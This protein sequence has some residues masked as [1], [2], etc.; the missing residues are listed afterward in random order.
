MAVERKK[1]FIIDLG[2]LVKTR[3][4]DF[5]KS[6]QRIH[7][8]E[9][10]DFQRNIIDNDLSYQDQLDYRKDLLKREKEKKY[11]DNDFIEEIKTSISNL[12]VLV[13]QRKWRDEY[14][15]FLSDRIAGRKS[16]QDYL[17]FLE[18]S[19]HEG[20]NREIRDK[21]EEEI[22]TTQTE[23]KKN[24]RDIVNSQITF[25][26]KD[27]TID[28]IDK[29]IGLIQKQLLK[30]D[31]QKDDVLRNSYQLQLLTLNKERTEVMI[32]DKISEMSISLIKEEKK[33]NALFKLDSY[34]NYRDS[35][36]T[37]RPVN[38]GGVRYDTEREYWDVLLNNYIVNEFEKDYVTQ[39]RKNMNVL[40]NK[41]GIFPDS[42][43][44]D[45]MA[46][47]RIIKNHPELVNFP[48][49]TL[50]A[51]Q[52]VVG[53]MLDL[54]AQDLTRKYHLDEPGIAIELD[55]F[56]AEKEL[57]DLQNTIG[58]EY[59]SLSPAIAKVKAKLILNK[60]GK[61]EKVLGD[62]K[63]WMNAV[64]DETGA[65]PTSE[66]ITDYVTKMTPLIT[67]E[68]PGETVYQKPVT[69]LA[70]TL[71]VKPEKITAPTPED[72]KKEEELKKEKEELEKKKAAEEEKK[73]EE[74]FSPE[75]YATEKGYTKY[76]WKT[77]NGKKQWYAN[78]KGEWQAVES[79]E[80]AREV[81]GL[82]KPIVTPTSVTT[83]M[84]E[85]YTVK[86]GETLWDIS[87]TFLGSGKRWK[88]LKTPE[89]VG[90]TEETAKQLQVGQK[91]IIPSK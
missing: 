63:D 5:V 1:E 47:S 64:Y 79:K 20:Y 91:L 4:N 66:E 52:Q 13:R 70:E 61:V 85:A 87:K 28:S 53:G 83:P 60:M 7:A 27:R 30:P 35:A 58:E 29:A 68:V 36:T 9:E 23:I 42:A 37:D 14:F 24:K 21:I 22:L 55:Y 12:R 84:P 49:V 65:F 25:Y 15:S 89:G 3:L 54:R 26:E 45:V 86:P 10:S 78:V 46:T 11:P 33:N 34:K 75:K 82:A 8:L 73:K 81:T 43:L 40:Y 50:S 88:E 38:I 17:E 59:I 18:A 90:F 41:L 57:E 51:I 71:V 56:S 44:K 19:L 48:E 39:A 69:E 16:L 6:R 32:E 80:K 67:A 74:V 31:I 72:V 2:D 77:I 62:V 76:F